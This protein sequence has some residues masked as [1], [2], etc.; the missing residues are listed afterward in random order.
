M[1]PP[2]SIAIGGYVIEMR[3]RALEFSAPHEIRL[4]DVVV[5]EPRENEMLV[6]TLYSGISAGTELLA[7]NG[8]I[9][10]HLVLDDAISS[11]GGTF[12]Y[13][14]RYGYSCVGVVERSESDVRP[15]TIVF[16]FHPHQDRFVCKATDMVVVSGVDQRLATMF[17]LAEAAFQIV[18]DSGDVAAEPVVVMGL[19]SVGLLTAWLLQRKGAQVLGVDPSGSRRAVARDLGI[20][21]VGPVDAVGRAEDL[22]DGLGAALVVEV[23]GNPDALVSGLGMLAHE[24]I[25]LVGSWYG[26]RT[27]PLPLGAEFHRRRL[28]IRSS[29]VSTIPAHLSSRWTMSR[30]RVHVARSLDDLPLK[31][32]AT[33]EFP[34]EDA[35]RA[36]DMLA[37]G[38]DVIHVALSYQQG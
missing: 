38:D 19:G 24:G 15:G 33:H 7:Y 20:E 12:S 22:T 13:P 18:L 1:H 11:L 36:F 30:R 8:E 21:A 3:A 29:Q 17:P 9:D 2:L 23:S 31:M 14:F 34:F 16:A 4:V 27:V 25:A 28:T 10:P 35:P 37:A 32:L 26:T 6:R 5:T